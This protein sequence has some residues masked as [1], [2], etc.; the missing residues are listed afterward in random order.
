MSSLFD[1]TDFSVIVKNS[2]PPPKPWRCEIYRAGLST[3]FDAGRGCPYQCSFCTIINM[4][5]RKSCFRTADDVEP[6]QL[7]AGHLQI[8]RHPAARTYK[9]T[10]LTPVSDDEE[11]TLDL[12]TSTT[13]AHAAVTHLKKIDRLTGAARS[14]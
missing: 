8:V 4:R 3:S 13:G 10:A 11:T 7:G 1:Q 9:D 14:V 6:S 2:A 5:G 12:L